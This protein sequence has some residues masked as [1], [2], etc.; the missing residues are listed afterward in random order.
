MNT[1]ERPKLRNVSAFPLQVS[2]K[3]VVGIQD[4][5][6]F[7]ENPVIVSENAFFIISHGKNILDVRFKILD[8][9]DRLDT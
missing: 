8:L 9:N 4:P 5:L 1:M 6:H 3:Q 7:S 2:G